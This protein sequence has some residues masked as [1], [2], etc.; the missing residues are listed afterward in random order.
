MNDF[1]L[2]SVI[3][4][5]YNK[6]EYLSETL[7]S[8]LNQAYSHWECI[9]VNDGS[10]DDSEEIAKEWINKDQRFKYIKTENQ[11]VSHARNVA[12]SKAQGTY[13]L[14][15]DADDKISK[16]Y[17]S[18]AIEAFSE[19]PNLKLVYCEVEWF[20][21]KSGKWKLKEFSLKELAKSN[22]IFCSA[23]FKKKD[24]ELAGKYDEKL[25]HGLEDWEFW[26]SLL[27]GGGE[28]YKIPKT[29]F[30]YRKVKGSR[31]NSI[32]EEQYNSIYNYIS[33]KHV[34]FY[35]KQLGSFHSLHHEYLRLKNEHIKKTTYKKEV[36]NSFCKTFFG[37]KLFK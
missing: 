28:V 27:K 17:T 5:C 33:I 16:D 13:I 1:P 15:L 21:Q 37:F 8:V 22:M 19:K 18:L 29:C 9:I 12:I 36:L 24:W 31:D 10:T 30:F 11:G 6:G 20:G 7:A 3:I 4:P 23:F 34:D 26:I 32:T 25:I 35:V 14:P 2:V